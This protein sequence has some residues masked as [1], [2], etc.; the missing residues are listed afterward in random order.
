MAQ[1]EDKEEKDEAEKKLL[2]TKE[3]THKVMEEWAAAHPQMKEVS[4]QGRR[5][6]GGKGGSSPPTTATANGED[7]QILIYMYHSTFS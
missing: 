7:C 5:N 1:A 4:T 3:L 6:Q 2:K